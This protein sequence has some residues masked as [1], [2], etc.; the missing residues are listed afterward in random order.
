MLAIALADTNPLVWGGSASPPGPPAGWPSRSAGRAAGRRSP[1]TPSTCC[2]V[3]EA[4]RPRDV[5]DD[6]FAE[7]P[8]DAAPV[9]LVLDDGTDDPVVREHRGRLEAAAASHGVRV[10]TVTTDAATEVARYASLVLSGRVRR[11]VPPPR[12]RRRLIAGGV[13]SARDRGTTG[14]AA[15]SRRRTWSVFGVA[16]VLLGAA[17]V[18]GLLMLRA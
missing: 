16:V 14:G 6:P 10:E 9:L 18:W 13:L 11:G 7:G 8:P 1:A 2:R 5:F 15:M 17:A 12:A 3:I 4:A